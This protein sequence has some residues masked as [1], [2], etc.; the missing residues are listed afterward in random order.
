MNEARAEAKLAL[1]M[2]Y[3]EEEDKVNETL[4]ALISRLKRELGRTTDFDIVSDRGRAYVLRKRKLD[5]WLF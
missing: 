4:Y 5:G 3:K 2:P 1:A